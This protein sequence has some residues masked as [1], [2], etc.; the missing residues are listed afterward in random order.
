VYQRLHHSE[1]AVLRNWRERERCDGDGL[2]K[3]VDANV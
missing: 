3:L 1:I 2:R